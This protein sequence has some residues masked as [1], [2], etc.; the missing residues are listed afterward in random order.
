VDWV[1][2]GWIGGPVREY[3]LCMHAIGQ[4]KEGRK[5]SDPTPPP[6]KDARTLDEEVGEP[7]DGEGAREPDGPQEEERS[8]PDRLGE[9]VV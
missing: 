7:E 3:R 4:I 2:L 9:Q 8:G 1:G 5:R 6:D